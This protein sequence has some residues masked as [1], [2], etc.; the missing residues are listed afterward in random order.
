[1]A[2]FEQALERLEAIVEEMNGEEIPL[3]R[4][5]ALFEEGIT[6]L[7]TASDELTRAESAVKVLVEKADGILEASDLGA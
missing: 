3:E 6:H 5:L 4:A 1:M 2:T 7:R